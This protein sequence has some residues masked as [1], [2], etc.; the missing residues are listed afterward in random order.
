MT[1]YTCMRKIHIRININ[2]WL[3]K[4]GESIGLKHFSDPKAFIEYSND[5]HDIYGNI[6]YYSPGKENKIF[7]VFDYMAADMINNKKLNSIVTELLGA[8][9]WMF[10]FSL[11]HN[12]ILKSQRMLD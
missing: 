10:L 8:E 7:I 9:N 2:F 3:I 12:D 6:N 11:L 1:K 4:E 5:M